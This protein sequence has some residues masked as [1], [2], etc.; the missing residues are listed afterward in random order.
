[1]SPVTGAGAASSD[2]E[3]NGGTSDQTAGIALQQVQ[4]LPGGEFGVATVAAV[5]TTAT[6]SS[7]L[8][9]YVAATFTATTTST[10]ATASVGKGDSGGRSDKGKGPASKHCATGS[11]LTATSV[12]SA[13]ASSNPEL[14]ATTSSITTAARTEDLDFGIILNSV[15]AAA[16]SYHAAARVADARVSS[17]AAAAARAHDRAASTT[18]PDPA[19]ARASA[20]SMD[21]YARSVA[22]RAAD[23][24]AAAAAADYVVAQARAFA[25]SLVVDQ[26]RAADSSVT[27]LDIDFGVILNSVVTTA[28]NCHAAAAAAA[29]RANFA[30]DARANFDAS[31]RAAVFT[32]DTDS[33]ATRARARARARS[34]ARDVADRVA[35]ARVAAAR[36]A[37]VAA[38]HVVAQAHA[39]AADLGIVQDRAADSCVPITGPDSDP[40]SNSAARAAAVAI[41]ASSL[42]PDPSFLLPPGCVDLF[43]FV[44]HSEFRE[45]VSKLI[46][47]VCALAESFYLCMVEIPASDALRGLSNTVRCAWCLINKKFYEAKF[48]AKCF[49]ACCANLLPEFIKH[50]CSVK[51]WDSSSRCFFPLMGNSLR[52][53]WTFLD[54]AI[55]RAV[56]SFFVAKWSEL[57]M[58]FSVSF[59]SQL[60]PGEGLSALC[61]GDFVDACA[62]AGTSS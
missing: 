48:V 38:D 10:S 35:A 53:F 28:R 50:L 1:M 13:S 26:D 24:H 39:F 23:A 45:V 30:A 42:R 18:D 36:A 2:P 6:T 54:Q 51:V 22:A 16:R 56:G 5:S 43:G 46:S 60:E 61:G 62:K 3:G 17:A 58:N 31:A 25:A 29:A 15:V 47:D 20:R 57:A 34:R 8:T 14:S 40:I 37:A 41:A 55:F 19:R 4:I 7:A 49:A 12:H 32:P 59:F 44:V 27:S 21:S 52:D 33:N 9:T 11:I